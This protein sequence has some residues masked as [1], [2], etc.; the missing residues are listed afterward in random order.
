MG[1]W[2]KFFRENVLMLLINAA[3]PLL[4]ALGFV[5]FACRTIGFTSTVELRQRL[6]AL[7]FGSPAWLIAALPN[8]VLVGIILEHRV[9]VDFLVGLDGRLH[10]N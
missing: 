10:L 7:V 9:L 3:K 5:I 4:S 1:G 2:G 6:S 8:R